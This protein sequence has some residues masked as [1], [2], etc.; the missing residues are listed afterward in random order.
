MARTWFSY[1]VLAMG[2]TM[3]LISDKTS[4]AEDTVSEEKEIQIF[5]NREG[6]EQSNVNISINGKKIDF[7]LPKLAE[8]ETK[9]MTLDDGTEV[10]IKAISGQN[11]IWIDGEQLE[12]PVL[13]MDGNSEGLHS[14]ISRVTP[15][16]KFGAHGDT[17]VINAD[18]SDDATAAI[19]DAVQNV[20][21]AYGIDKKVMVRKSPKMKFITIDGEQ[22]S[23]DKMEIIEEHI[24]GGL[25]GEVHEIKIIKEIEVEKEGPN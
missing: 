2:L 3:L 9:T 4:H 18:V 17:V 19:K 8:G 20:L 1:I 14:I 10:I 6:D 7:Q 11:N 16:M 23:S 12:V 22:L 5:V 25:N 15:M 13:H 24:K 21:T